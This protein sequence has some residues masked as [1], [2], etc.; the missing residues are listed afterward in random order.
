[1]KTILLLF[2]MFLAVTTVSA[3]LLRSGN[4]EVTVSNE[5]DVAMENATVQ[6]LAAKDSS[7]IKT[8]ITDGKGVAG[9][10]HIPFGAYR[11]KATMV[12]HVDQYSPDVTLSPDAALQVA[13]ALHHNTAQMKEVVVEG[14][15]PFIQKLSDRIVVNVDNSIISTGSSAMDILERSPGVNVDQNDVISLRG[16]QGV[17]IM[18]D[19][20]PTPMSGTDL[21]NYLKGLPSSVIDRV[22]IIT[23]PS[24]KYDA[25]GN[26]GIIDIHMKKDQHLGAN[27]NITA[28]AGQG[29]YSKA[30]AG[31]SFNYR[32]KR[33]NVFGNY[34][35]A[36]RKGLNHLII[37]RNFYTDGIFN[38]EDKKDN[39]TTFPMNFHVARLGADFFIDKKTIV[40]FVVNSNFFDYRSLNSN[41][42]SVIDNQKQPSYTFQTH[43]TSN[44]GNTNTVGNINFKHTFDSTG[45]E[46]TADID[47]GVYHST[48]LSDNAT[49]YFQ[50]D[51]A[52]LQPPY[53]LLSNQ[54]GKLT[55]KTGKVDYVNPMKKGAKLEAG[56]KISD[57][58]SDNDA[59]FFDAS[60]GTP[61]ND[62]TK[63]NHFLYEE[64]NTAGYINFSKEY[65]K[66]NIQ[67]GLRGEQTR[68]TTHQVKGDIAFDSAY[69]QLFPSAF[70]NYKL[71]ADQTLGV[72]VSRRIDRP[73]YSSLNPFLFLIDVSTYNTG[74]T[75]LLPQLTWSYEVNYTVKNLNFAL[76][77]SHIK[78]VQNIAIA[79]FKDV[80]PNSHFADSNITV[81]IPVNLSSSD[82]V[83]LS[84]SA[85]VNIFPWWSMINNA[86]IYYNHFRG[87]L[88]GSMLN[89][90][91]PAAD[92]KTN[93]TFSF[94]KGW[95]AEL[96]ANFNSGGRDG[97][98][99]SQPQWGLSSGIQKM[100]LKNKGTLRF[101]VTDIFWTDLPKAV[102]TYPGKYIE[103]W[104]AFRESR[105]GTLTFTYRFGRTTVAGAR[106]R[107]T[108]SEEERQRAQ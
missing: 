2:C 79:K 81:E 67:L 107:S 69:F 1:M 25:S 10:E 51:G 11:L 65:K 19:G 105:V 33:V 61:V 13:I 35:Y 48:A 102:I 21:A 36:Y 42:S 50:L 54:H 92:I 59:R 71:T 72:S 27:G 62:T 38:G 96:N 66:F 104:H 100:V 9:F 49:N 37:D 63:T 15:R 98:M 86:D 44:A 8:A 53:I 70:F 14:K 90:G 60:S 28:G 6:L 7:L 24:A 43:Q 87:D 77:Y 56:F 80:F 74:N 83:G 101:N 5:S 85:P 78:D 32:N 22:D 31:A 45:K 30:N 39:Y 55:L 57:V 68:F 26:S 29:I 103:R 46:L 94:K 41:N 84:I 75:A 95:T 108:G 91:A 40:G 93:N 3:Q 64:F 97:Y 89:N 18:I 34:N 99:V 20:K 12:N 16:R 58:A 73:N 88:G 82:Y 76:S 47:Y 23:N 4:I 17:I 106:K 52:T